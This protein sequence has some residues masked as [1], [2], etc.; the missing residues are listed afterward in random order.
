MPLKPTRHANNYMNEVDRRKNKKLAL[1]AVCHKLLK[2]VFG[3][4]KNQTLFN[5]T[6]LKISY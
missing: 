5:N 6:Y 4:V 3:V 1:I 2:Q